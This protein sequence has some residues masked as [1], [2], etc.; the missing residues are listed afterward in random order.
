M[1]GNAIA[2]FACDGQVRRSNVLPAGC[3]LDSTVLRVAG[4]WSNEGSHQTA[5]GLY[6]EAR[7][8]LK[9]DTCGQ[10]KKDYY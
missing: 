1:R 9:V 10:S 2:E 5:V 6:F 4:A 3:Y 7:A 8:A